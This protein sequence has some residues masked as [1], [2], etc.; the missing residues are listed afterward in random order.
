MRWLDGITHSTDVSLSKLRELVMDREAWR[1]AV[2]GVAKSWT[3]LSDWTELN[4]KVFWSNRKKIVLCLKAF[5]KVICSNVSLP[6]PIV[7]FFFNI[8]LLVVLG[9]RCCVR[10]FLVAVCGLS[11]IAVSRGCSS[12][13]CEG[14]TWHWFLS[15]QSLGSRVHGLQ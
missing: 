1:A 2:H 4:S 14:F 3:R 15:S 12:L 11:L 9:L 5:G 8:Y 10:A 6:L 7:I 13:L